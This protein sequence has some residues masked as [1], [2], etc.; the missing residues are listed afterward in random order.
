[1]ETPLV[2][3]HIDQIIYEVVFKVLEE[4]FRTVNEKSDTFLCWIYLLIRQ[5]AWL[6]VSEVFIQRLGLGKAGSL[7]SSSVNVVLLHSS[8]E[9]VQLVNQLLDLGKLLQTTL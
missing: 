3:V 8:E 6:C 4:T 7:A 9:G 2:S 1:M 5:A